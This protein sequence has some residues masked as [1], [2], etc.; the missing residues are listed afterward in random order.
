MLPACAA[1]RH[2][3]IFEAA[4]LIG[5]DA[6]IHQRKN[7]GEKLVHAFLLIE[8]VDHRSIFPRQ[9]LK[10]LLASGI[11][12][13]AAIEN[14]APAVTAFVFRHTA[15]K[16]KAENSHNKI[17]GGTGN[18]LQ[19]LRREHTL[20]RI[21]HRWQLDRQS[22]VMEQPPQ[23]LQGIRNALQKMSFSLIKSAE[24]IGAQ[25]LHNAHVDIAVVVAQEIFAIRNPREP[26]KIILKIVK[27][28][29]NRLPFKAGDR[30]APF[31]IKTAPRLDLE[32]R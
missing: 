23:I 26:K 13:A 19:L 21:H 10:A 4:L 25:R 9:F 24:A 7:A 2:H 6:C 17:I 31:I 16:R 8:V 3:Q 30:I 29:E 22:Y 27:P 15:M 14:K 1:E 28:Q 5:G 12:K 18:S 11:G 32:A 20:E